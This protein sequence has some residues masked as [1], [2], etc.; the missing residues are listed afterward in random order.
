MNLTVTV[1]AQEGSTVLKEQVLIGVH[2]QQVHTVTGL[3]CIV[4]SSAKTVMLE[5]TA[6][7]GT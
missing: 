7:G 4:R 5:N 1:S 6:M 2:V 3:V